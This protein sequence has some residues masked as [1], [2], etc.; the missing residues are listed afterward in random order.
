[1]VH[2]SGKLSDPTVEHSVA[3]AAALAPYN[4]LKRTFLYPVIQPMA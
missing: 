2:V 4:I 1:M 3:K